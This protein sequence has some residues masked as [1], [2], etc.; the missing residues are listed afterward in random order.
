MSSEEY[1]VEK[2]LDHKV[3]K[4][5]KKVTFKYLIK[6][7]NYDESD[8]TWE[9]EANIFATDLIV[10]YWNT[11]PDHNPDKKLHQSLTGQSSTENHKVASVPVNVP[12]VIAEEST[13]D[14]ENGLETR[15]QS[16]I[17]VR[18]GTTEGLDDDVAPKT[19]RIRLLVNNN[20][21]DTSSFYNVEV[22]SSTSTSTSLYSVGAGSSSIMEGEDD[23]KS[24]DDIIFNETFAVDIDDWQKAAKK[25]EYI[26]REVEGSPMFCIVKWQNGVRS[27]HPLQVVRERCPQLL[28]D[29]F[30]DIIDNK[31]K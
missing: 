30:V 18:E 10:Q 20:N 24:D 22:D 28:I 8:N 19:K 1:E 9:R 4:R 15:E 23:D 29:A 25:V 7:L 2:I 6:W 27:M 11:V 17:R 26:G 21:V 13:D 12:R 3:I 5:G 14:E 16:M 31:K